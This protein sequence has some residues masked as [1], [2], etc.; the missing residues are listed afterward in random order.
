MQD[1]TVSLWERVHEAEMCSI[2]SRTRCLSGCGYVTEKSRR[3]DVGREGGG[4][5]PIMKSL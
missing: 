4:K 1:L 3:G 5:R 2:S